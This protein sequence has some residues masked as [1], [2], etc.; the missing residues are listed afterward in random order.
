MKNIFILIFTLIG[1]NTTIKKN[2]DSFNPNEINV[3]KSSNVSLLNRIRSNPGI[4]IEGVGVNAKVFT[5]GVSSINNQKEVLFILNGVQVGSYS[6][7]VNIL[8][9]ESIKS[10]TI[11]KNANDISIY[12]FKGSGGVILIKTK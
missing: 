4:Y 12:G 11:L 6:Q 5:K 3:S 7:I 10:I 2:V 9:P 1:C 8:N